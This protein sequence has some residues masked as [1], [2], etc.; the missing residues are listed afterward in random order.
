MDPKN[1]PD[2]SD[3]S[4]VISGGCNTLRFLMHLCALEA[5]ADPVEWKTAWPIRTSH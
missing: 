2:H 3:A 1:P 4:L 5:P